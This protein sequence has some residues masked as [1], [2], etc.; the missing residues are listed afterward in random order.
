MDA[1]MRLLVKDY[2]QGTSSKVRSRVGKVSGMVGIATNGILILIK[3]IGGLLSGSIAIIGDAVNNMSDVASSVVV[4]VGFHLSKKPADDEH[5]YGHARIEYVSGILISVVILFLGLQLGMSS[6]EA[7]FD[8]GETVFSPLVLVLLL[9]SVGVKCWQCLFYRK[10]GRKIAST[11]VLAASKDSLN[12]ILATS[13][14]FIGAVITN[15]TQVNLDGYL[16]LAVAAF[17]V[18]SG[19]RSIMET[20][21]PL[22]GDP[23]TEEMTR[24]VSEK[25]MTYDGILGVHDL[26]AHQYGAGHCFATVHC[27]V[28]GEQSLTEVHNLIDEIERE[29]LTMLEIHLVIHPE[30]ASQNEE[31]EQL[32]HIIQRDIQVRYP[33][34]Q[35]HD[36]RVVHRSQGDRVLFDTAIPF[37]ETEENEAIKKHMISV[38]TCHVPNAAVT[39]K[40]DRVRE[41]DLEYVK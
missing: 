12:D 9:I 26:V 39:I 25:L 22:L 20:S 13:V 29:F 37:G 7:I 35:L 10:V 30:P 19:V 6:V 28:A 27:E 33:K 1:L 11:T 15:V 41:L 2:D 36:F 8:P 40:L 38:V 31:T 3:L 34:V 14:V 23:L 16:G 24:T 4:L 21:A 32:K 18:I 5:P 17:V